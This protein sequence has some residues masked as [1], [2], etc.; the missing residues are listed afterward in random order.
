MDL[1]YWLFE[2][3][4]A[5]ARG[6]GLEIVEELS[7]CDR[8]WGGFLR[9]SEKS[10]PRFYAAYWQGVEVPPQADGIRLDPKIL[11]VAPG[12]RLSLQ[13]H[14]RRSEHWRVLDG[15]VRIE[16]GPDG[17]HLESLEFNAGEVVRIP[18]GAWHRLQGLQGWGRIAE[19]WQ[20]VDPQHPS[21]EDDIV[22]VQDDFGRVR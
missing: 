16:I 22:R 8:P 14:H 13:Y 9:F 20:S 4:K 1:K 19:I 12:S 17:S 3:L 10:I 15:P 21:D 6:F 5:E 18:C 7:S 2:R 11:L